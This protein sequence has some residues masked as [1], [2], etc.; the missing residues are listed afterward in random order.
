M[1]HKFLVGEIGYSV[2]AA[3]IIRACKICTACGTG[4]D[5]LAG[6][7]SVAS[8]YIS[9]LMAQVDEKDCVVVAADLTGERLVTACGQDDLGHVRP[10]LALVVYAGHDHFPCFR[11]LTVV[12]ALAV[13]RYS[14]GDGAEPNRDEWLAV[15]HELGLDFPNLPYLID[16]DVRITQ[17]Q[18]I[19][20]YLGQK[21]GLVPEGEETSRR[22]E[23]LQHQAFDM[24]WDTAR[25]SYDP[26][27]TEDKR[28]QFLTDVAERLRQLQVYLDKYGPYGAGRMITYVDFMVYESLQPFPDAFEPLGH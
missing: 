15:K 27:Y 9:P 3:A 19:M 5:A 20:R 26:D 11:F 13:C 22:V 4:C 21:H 24:L 1:S 28:R 16:G 2:A 23:V 7:A 10:S 14:F 25:L 12:S 8:S 18:V 17:S 6:L